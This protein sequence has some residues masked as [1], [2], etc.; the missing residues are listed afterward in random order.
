MAWSD[1]DQNPTTAPATNYASG[2]S[3][4]SYNPAAYGPVSSGATTAA[5]AATPAGGSYS[6][7]LSEGTAAPFETRETTGRALEKSA[8]PRRTVPANMSAYT[9]PYSKSGRA[10]PASQGV[11]LQAEAAR[12]GIAPSTLASVIGY[13]T[14]GSFDP[15]IVGGKKNR[16]QGLIQMGPRERRQYGWRDD[17]SFEEQLAGPV[18][19]Y[20][21]DRGVRPGH[22]I[23]EVYSIINA[24]SL[25]RGQP[26]WG[27]SDRP[28]WNIRRHAG[29]I[30]RQ[31]PQYAYLDPGAATDQINAPETMVAD[32]GTDVLAGGAV[33]SPRMRPQRSSVSMAYAPTPEEMEDPFGA[34]LGADRR[35][36]PATPRMRPQRDTLQAAPAAAAE[37]GAYVVRRGDNLSKIAARELGDPN[38]WREIAAANR[39]RDPNVIQPGQRLVIPGQTAQA[40]PQ[41]AVP[42]PR[43]RPSREVA[44]PQPRP[45]PERGANVPTPRP[46]PQQQAAPASQPQQA[47]RVP[48]E[49]WNEMGLGSRGNAETQM[50]IDRP[51]QS[52]PA[53][54]SRTAPRV[55]R[56]VWNSMGLGSRGNAETQMSIDRSQSQPAGP[57]MDTSGLIREPTAE[58]RALQGQPMRA[59]TG[60][61][62][63]DP[64]VAARMDMADGVYRSP[65][66]MVQDGPPIVSPS[67]NVQFVRVR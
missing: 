4:Y 34:V 46:R 44:M 25:R 12:L 21:V 37:A 52:A 38:R 42:Q 61:Q 47:P 23:A 6:R 10:R 53:A 2:L 26:R 3:G 50:S 63:I 51:P 43:L 11:A 67:Y 49:T 20:L 59:P 65:T 62:P 39:I 30:S 35:P 18:H 58:E 27:A 33:P 15:G 45:R 64:A 19:N 17:M 1:S 41:T 13:E 40:R 32:A 31:Q 9:D 29:E 16:Y 7:G 60:N 28:G 24:G 14:I 54:A 5:T 8:S 48:R 66:G 57:G 36:Q 56:E 22:G 55:P